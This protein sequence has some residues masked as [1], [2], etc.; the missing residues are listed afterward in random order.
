[1]ENITQ[2]IKST[3][4]LLALFV[5]VCVCERVCLLDRFA[6]INDATTDHYFWKMERDYA[7]LV[8]AALSDYLSQKYTSGNN[9]MEVTRIKFTTLPKGIPEYSVI[10]FFVLSFI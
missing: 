9:K 2:Y 5:C 8:T 3:V 10:L 6:A 4:T 1:M 7:G